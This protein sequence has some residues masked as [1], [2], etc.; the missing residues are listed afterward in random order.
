MEDAVSAMLARIQAAGAMPSGSELKAFQKESLV[1]TGSLRPE[2][3]MAVLRI[4]ANP[5]SCLQ[6]GAG[7]RKDP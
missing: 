6:G 5:V 2:Q 1:P 7:G 4:P 3:V